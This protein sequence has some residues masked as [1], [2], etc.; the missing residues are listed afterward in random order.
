LLQRY[1]GLDEGAPRLS[2]LGGAEWSRVKKRAKESVQ[3][4]AEGLLKLYAE[5]E[6]APGFAF[7]PDGPWQRELEN[8]FP[9]QE[10]PDQIQAIE[11]V[12]R[13]MEKG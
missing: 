4:M 11:A 6:A 12:K 5:R 2:K 7:P 8:S 1:V 9:Y 13:D 3:E 10:T